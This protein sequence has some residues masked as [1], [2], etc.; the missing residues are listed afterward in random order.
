MRREQWTAKPWRD[1][2]SILILEA[3]ALVK[4]LER[5]RE[6]LHGLRTRQYLSCDN[7]AFDRSRAKSFGVSDTRRFTS[8]LLGRDLAITVRWTSS[9]F[10]ETSEPSR[11][12]DPNFDGTEGLTDVITQ[13]SS[14]SMC[15]A[16]G[17]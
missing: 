14:C 17:T 13:A 15:A 10:N 3:R 8:F 1:R 9:R 5:M 16:T 11:L 2:E 7:M 12:S 6:S 4:S